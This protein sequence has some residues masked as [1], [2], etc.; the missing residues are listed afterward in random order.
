MTNYSAEEEELHRV[1]AEAA[2]STSTNPWGPVG[3]V[4]ARHAGGTGRAIGI[5]DSTVIDRAIGS[6]GMLK[7][8]AVH[9]FI[10]KSK[11]GREPADLDTVVLKVR[12][13]IET[14]PNISTAV[15]I[16]YTNDY[17]P[18]HLLSSDATVG[19][20]LSLAYPN[21][22][23]S[24]GVQKRGVEQP[25][26]PWRVIVTSRSI[27]SSGHPSV[28][29]DDHDQELRFVHPGDAIL[30]FQPGD[31]VPFAL[32]RLHHVY[33]VDDG[34]IVLVFDRYRERPHRRDQ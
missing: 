4:L 33:P 24:T 7:P 23:L 19:S 28:L 13:Q 30:L 2:S 27:A 17:Y 25:R 29:V 10:V 31:T 18:T 3:T 1:S 22:R 32:G 26:G 15:I 14:S 11:E 16:P 9:G 20:K 5:Q 34:G 12:Q 8:L 6:P 21:A